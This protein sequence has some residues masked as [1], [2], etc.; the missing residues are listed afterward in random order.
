ML[1]VDL[2]EFE[3]WSLI[4]REKTQGKRFEN[5]VLRKIFGVDEEIS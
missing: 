4:L 2:Y 3:T 1:P 5:R